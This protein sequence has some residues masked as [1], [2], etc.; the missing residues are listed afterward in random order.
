MDKQLKYRDTALAFT[1]ISILTFHFTEN[2][3]WVYLCMILVL[4]AMVM[5]Q[6]YKIPSQ[7]WFGLSEKMGKVVSKVVLS[8]IFYIIL[9]PLGLLRRVFQKNSHAVDS[10]QFSD[11]QYVYTKEDFKRIF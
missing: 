11:R 6:A 1:F 3:M 9:T 4:L 2:T 7:L 8:L 5:P 10:G